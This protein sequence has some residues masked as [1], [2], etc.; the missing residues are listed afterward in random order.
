[1]DDELRNEGPPDE[2]D[3]YD[4]FPTWGSRK[5]R[6]EKIVP[7]VRTEAVSQFCRKCDGSK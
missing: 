2:G 6:V 4:Y 7:V 3:G 1:M 5:D